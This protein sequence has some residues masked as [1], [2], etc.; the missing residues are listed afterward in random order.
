MEYRSCCLQLFHAHIGAEMAN[1]SRALHFEMPPLL[2]CRVRKSIIET[3]QSSQAGD[4]NVVERAGQYIDF[5]RESDPLRILTLQLIE[6]KDHVVVM[7]YLPAVDGFISLIHDS[8]FEA[9]VQR[10]CTKIVEKLDP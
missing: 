4:L 10:I 2:S 5:C 3:L 7:G 8:Q 1:A 9:G 6:K